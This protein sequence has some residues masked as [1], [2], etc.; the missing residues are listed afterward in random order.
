MVG[1]TISDWQVALASSRN[2]GRL[3]S[4]TSPRGT[5]RRSS[6]STARKGASGRFFKCAFSP[7]M[8]R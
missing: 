8:P 3:S 7:A 1:V 6:L 5:P 2:H 4:G